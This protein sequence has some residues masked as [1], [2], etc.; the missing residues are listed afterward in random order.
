MKAMPGPDFNTHSMGMRVARAMSPTKEKV[1][2]PAKKLVM[3]DSNGSM[4]P[5]LNK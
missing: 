5:S 1:T 2:K 3:D 4:I